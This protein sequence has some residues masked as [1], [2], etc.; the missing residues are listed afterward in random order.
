MVANGEV[1]RFQAMGFDLFATYRLKSTATYVKQDFASAYPALS[2]AAEHLRREMQARGGR[3][4]GAFVPGVNG[5]VALFV[6]REVVTRLS[7]DI[8]RQRRLSY[9]L[10]GT[11]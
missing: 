3:R 6:F 11:G 2:E 8:G 5:L 4:N 1:F 7:Q 10:Q 9:I